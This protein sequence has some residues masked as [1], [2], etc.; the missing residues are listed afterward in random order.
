MDGYEVKINKLLNVSKDM[1]DMVEVIGS[2]IDT[3]Q[4]EFPTGYKSL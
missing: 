3:K 2:K 1:I 4:K